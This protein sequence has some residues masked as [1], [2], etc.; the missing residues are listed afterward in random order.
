MSLKSFSKAEQSEKANALQ[1]IRDAGGP[2]NSTF[3]MVALVS[4]YGGM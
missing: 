1:V 3:K 2:Q 4:P